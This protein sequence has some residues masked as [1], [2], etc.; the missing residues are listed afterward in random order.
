MEKKPRNIFEQILFGLETT[1][2][3]VVALSEE[4]AFLRKDMQDLKAGLYIDTNL[5]G[6]NAL[7]TDEKGIVESNNIQNYE[8]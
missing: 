2:A 1:T 4:I 8:L 3:N 5:S 6:P 7:G